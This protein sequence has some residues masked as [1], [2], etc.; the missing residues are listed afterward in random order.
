[1]SIVHPVPN[2]IEHIQDRTQKLFNFNE[3]RIMELLENVQYGLG[4][5]GLAFIIGVSLDYVFPKY[6]E[7]QDTRQVILE[8]ALQIVLLIVGAFYIRK[9]VKIMP[10]LFVINF[11]IDGDGRIPKY[12]PYESTEFEGE[13]MMGLVFVASQRN[14]LNKIDLVS[15]RLYAYLKTTTVGGFI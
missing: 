11:D 3:V 14:L 12:R 15:E 5:M 8:I 7:E 13:L 2:A 1:M 4:Y 6:D 9:I 10:F